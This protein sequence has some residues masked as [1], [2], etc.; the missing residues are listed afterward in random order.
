MAKM[1]KADIIEAA[2]TDLDNVV[3]PHLQKNLGL[4]FR[5]LKVRAMVSRVERVEGGH[6]DIA[7]GPCNR[8]EHVVQP[9][10]ARLAPGPFLPR[11]PFACPQVSVKFSIRV[12]VRESVQE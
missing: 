6:V 9:R 8:F 7:C 10:L 12:S 11:L 4:P 5:E 1:T 3:G 2:A